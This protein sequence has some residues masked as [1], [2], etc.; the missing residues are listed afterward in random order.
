MGGLER[1]W[2]FF[3][4]ILKSWFRGLATYYGFENF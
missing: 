2:N 4:N 1:N 3:E